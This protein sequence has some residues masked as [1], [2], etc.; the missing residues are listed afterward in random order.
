MLNKDW[1]YGTHSNKKIS[2]FLHGN[3]DAAVSFY[4]LGYWQ[5]VYEVHQIHE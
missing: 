2:T 1:L 4:L 5:R 3:F